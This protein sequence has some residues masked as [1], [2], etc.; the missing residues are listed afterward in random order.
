MNRIRTTVGVVAGVLGLAAWSAAEMGSAL[1]PRLQWPGVQT[2]LQPQG[3]T[4]YL[5]SDPSPETFQWAKH[6]GVTTVIN[7][8][9]PG[10]QRFQEEEAAK[11]QGLRYLRI[12]IDVA[13]PSEH[14]VQW[15][16]HLVN[17]VEA[18]DLLIHCDVG[19]RAL[20]MWAIYRGTVGG[21]SPKQALAEAQQAGLHHKGLERF[22][23]AY[24]KRYH[25][26]AT[27]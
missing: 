24:L 17:Q 1:L 12:P 3:T 16:L 14:A 20:A 18:K 11:D 7:L 10:E 6:Q 26:Q 27:S 21:C 2:V 22:V 19:G 4:I 15:F 13:Q 9:M 25:Q 23:L 8:M 5:S